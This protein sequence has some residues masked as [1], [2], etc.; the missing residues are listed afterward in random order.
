MEQS[1]GNVCC[2]SPTEVSLQFAPL[3]PQVPGNKY[4]DNQ[5]PQQFFFC[6]YFA[7][8]NPLTSQHFLYMR[9]CICEHMYHMFVL[10]VCA[11]LGMCMCVCMYVHVQEY[12]Q[13]YMYIFY[14]ECKNLFIALC[15]SQLIRLN[16]LCAVYIWRIK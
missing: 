13:F 12:A 6:C 16:F 9:M 1:T 5:A 4:Q 14:I 8:Y 15:L 10:Y 11:Y 3:W 2:T 7:E